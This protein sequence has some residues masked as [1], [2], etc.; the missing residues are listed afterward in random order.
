M[1]QDSIAHIVVGLPVEGPFDYSVP[2]E[3]RDKV[4]VGVRVLVSFAGR[5]RVGVVVSLGKKPLV[6]KV[7][8]VLK[9]LDETP[10]FEENALAFFREF[11][12]HFGCSFGEAL[13]LSLPASLRK[14]RRLKAWDRTTPVGGDPAPRTD[15]LFDCGLKKRWEII[16]PRVEETLRSGRGVIVLVPDASHIVEAQR[17]LETLAREFRGVLL[18]HGTDKEELERWIKVRSGASRLVLGF[19]SGVLAP[20]QDPGL[21]VVL[22]E[23]S[24]FYKHDQSPFYH[25]REAALLRARITKADV[26]LVSS[27]PS[28]EAWRMV[29]EKKAALIVGERPVCPVKLLDLS[30]FKMKKGTVISPGLS[31]H[32]ERVLKEGKRALIYVP[33]ARGTAPTVEEVVRRF[34]GVCVRGY[35]KTSGAFPVEA[36][37]VVATQAVFRHRGE[38]LFALSVVADIDWERHKNDRRASHQTF[39][40]VRHLAQMTSGLVLLQT[41]NV[42][43]EG[44]HALLSEDAE[45]FYRPELK[46]C[47]DM[48]LPPYAVL[49]AVV[50][51]SADPEL[52]C[53]EAK[54]LYDSFHAARPEDM[55]ILEPQPDRSPIV[56]GKFR[57][58]IMVHGVDVEETVGFVRKVLRGFRP[59]KDA[60][61]TVNVDP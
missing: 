44:L 11:A 38:V 58:C 22:E 10:A 2:E 51:R 27:A 20:V 32:L 40:L 30:N 18:R 37:V 24:P 33:A 25:A 7:L 43:D 60:V 56:R 8:P 54:R 12:L 29:S 34:P 1:S 28:L 16:L 23:D 13:E 39:A 36:Q 48:G 9:V 21:I 4:L 35:E 50:V 31:G 14:S 59:R 61:V 41:R 3:F 52:A 49:V 19:I 47:R 17:R 5:K 46:A 26:L 53:A 45:D 6:E 55:G 15:L 57:H 42:H